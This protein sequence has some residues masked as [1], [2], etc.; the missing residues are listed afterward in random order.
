MREE[1]FYLLMKLTKNKNQ[2]YNFDNNN[3]KS[4]PLFL[5]KDNTVR[6]YVEWEIFGKEP[7][8]QNHLR[9]LEDK[10]NG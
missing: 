6:A 1:E 3:A 4:Q 2:Y 9:P 8:D 7:D 5:M 10:T